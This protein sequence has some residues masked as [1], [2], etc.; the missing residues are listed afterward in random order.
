MKK[1]IEL[2]WEYNYW[3]NRRLLA[4]A[5]KLTEA[6]LSEKSPYMWDSIL[7]TMAHMLGAEWIWRQRTAEGVSPA[8]ILD[9]DQ[10]STLAMLTKRWG[11]EEAAMRQYLVGLTDADLE[12][13]VDYQNTAGTPFS[14][15]LWQILTHVVNHGTQHRSEVAL[16]LTNFGQS[17]GDMDMI[18]FLSERSA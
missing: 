17:P 13:V 7:G 15:P 6:Q 4:R 1:Q 14:R 9:R 10:F 11:E 3:A 18:V 12:R 8:A 5:D 16:S 2:L